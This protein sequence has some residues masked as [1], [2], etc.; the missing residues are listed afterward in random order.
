M[1]GSGITFVF[2]RFKDNLFIANHADILPSTQFSIACSS[3][4]LLLAQNIFVSS[5]E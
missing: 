5:A 1:D 2:D 4:K 3:F